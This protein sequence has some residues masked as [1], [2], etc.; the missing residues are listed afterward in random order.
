M[1]EIEVWSCKMFIRVRKKTVGS[2]EHREHFFVKTN[3]A[4]TNDRPAGYELAY[5]RKDGF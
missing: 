2:T 3:A 5:I 1:S 4:L